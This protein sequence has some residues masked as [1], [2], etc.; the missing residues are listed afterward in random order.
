[1]K[2]FRIDA[3]EY[4]VI[5]DDGTLSVR[6]YQLLYDSETGYSAYRVYGRNDI[7]ETLMRPFKLIKKLFNLIFEKLS[8]LGGQD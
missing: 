7:F 2:N 8:S 3:F 4:N 5:Y 6:T 1:M